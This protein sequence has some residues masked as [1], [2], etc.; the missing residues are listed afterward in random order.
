MVDSETMKRLTIVLG[1]TACGWLGAQMVAK[2]PV[3]RKADQVDDYHG[4]KVADPYRWLEDTDSA[5]TAQWVAAENRVTQDYLSKISPRSRFKDRLTT[6]YNYERYARFEKAGPRY[7]FQRN[8][9]LQNQNVIYAA[10]TLT[11]KCNAY[12][13][14]YDDDDVGKQARTVTRNGPLLNHAELSLSGQGRKAFVGR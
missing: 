14:V 13:Y 8:D 7:L 1:M 12:V 6:L 2:Y 9:G 4:T 11:G 3:A 5:E 10:D